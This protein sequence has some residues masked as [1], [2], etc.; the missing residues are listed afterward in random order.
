MLGRPS[1]PPGESL[2]LRGLRLWF[3]RFQVR[4][5]A[6]SV[7]AV[8]LSALQAL[9]QPGHACLDHLALLRQPLQS[10][11]WRTLILPLVGGKPAPALQRASA[12]LSH[13]GLGAPDTPVPSSTARP[14]GPRTTP[15][16]L[17]HA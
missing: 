1:A 17:E 2:K 8:R 5:K 16:P 3:H 6:G 4:E 14:S 11:G 12:P 15:S 7:G 9:G 13:S 10:Q